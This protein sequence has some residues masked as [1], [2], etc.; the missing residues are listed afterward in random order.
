MAPN[1][2][3]GGVVLVNIGIF[4]GVI[5]AFVAFLTIAEPCLDVNTSCKLAIN[6]IGYMNFMVGTLS[7]Q[8]I[9]PFFALL[10]IAMF[11][12][13]SPKKAAKQLDHQWLMVFV[14]AVSVVIAVPVLRLIA[15]TA[16]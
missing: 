8:D 4:G 7:V 12:V 2:P 11:R 1:L 9:G 3:Y 16:G 14:V 15:K 13:S 6:T 5:S 10:I